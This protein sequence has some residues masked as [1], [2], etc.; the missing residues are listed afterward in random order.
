MGRDHGPWPVNSASKEIQKIPEANAMD[1]DRM[2]K[3]FT[4]KVIIQYG[5]SFLLGGR[6][7]WR[8]CAA[9]RAAAAPCGAARGRR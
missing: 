3:N 7:L 6:I 9:R 4:L 2:G 1:L 5:G 8:G